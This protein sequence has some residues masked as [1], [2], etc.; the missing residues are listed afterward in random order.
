MLRALEVFVK[1]KLRQYFKNNYATR[2]KVKLE[3]KNFAIVSNNCWGGSNYQWLNKPY[4]SPF[5]GLFMYGPCYLKLLQNFDFYMG[6][7][8]LFVDVSKYEDREKTYPVGLLDDVE[9]HFT[10]YK[11]ST[12]AQLKWERRKSRLQ[13]LKS[14]G[15]LFF[16]ICDRERVDTEIIKEFHKLPFENKLSFGALPI[17]GLKDCEHVKIYERPKSK[18]PIVPNGRKLFKLSFLYVDLVHWFNSGK[19]KRTRFKY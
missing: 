10:H 1:R 7:Q 18:N 2:D 16:M 13:A 5:I 19:I 14:K 3:N 6:Q 8:L 15:N 9:V 12:E 11:D 17:D 4:N